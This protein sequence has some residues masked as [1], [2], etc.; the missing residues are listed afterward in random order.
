MPRFVVPALPRVI[1]QSRD[2]AGWF[3]A[4]SLLANWRER[5]RARWAQNDNRQSEAH[6]LRADGSLAPE[7]VRRLVAQF[8]LAPVPVISHLPTP[9]ELERLLHQYGPLWTDAVGVDSDG[10]RAKPGHVVVIGGVDTSP[11]AP[12]IY[13][14][15]PWPDER[16][17]EGWRPYNQ[18]NSLFGAHYGRA[19]VAPPCFL[20]FP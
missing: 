16:G 7:E 13:V 12:R 18:L 8:G 4:A 1:P 11:A 2:T 19:K 3:A 10:I 6:R 14:L 15:D 5:S 17:H 9:Q 20:N